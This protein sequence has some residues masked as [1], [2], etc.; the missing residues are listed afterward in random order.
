M[1]Y[2]PGKPKGGRH[3]AAAEVTGEGPRDK[4]CSQVCVWG[5][6]RREAAG[7]QPLSQMF[8]LSEQVRLTD[9]PAGRKRGRS[10][11]REPFSG[12][13]NL[14][15]APAPRGAGTGRTER[16]PGGAGGVVR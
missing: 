4:P 6:C 2:L 16:E 1:T 14:A 5:G 9:S 8:E 13:G 3:G 12:S 15:S 7:R 10:L 11:Q